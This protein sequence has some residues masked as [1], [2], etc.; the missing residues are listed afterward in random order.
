MTT[1]TTNKPA[2]IFRIGNISA[3]VWKRTAKDGASIFYTVQFQRS[4]RVDE[5]I[6]YTDSFNHD[7]LPNVAVLARRTERWIAESA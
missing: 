3:S 5:G 7:D 4:Y 6:Q 1:T 2:K